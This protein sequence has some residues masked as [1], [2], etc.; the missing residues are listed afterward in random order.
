M[1]E[2]IKEC[3]AGL[4]TNYSLFNIMALYSFIQFTSSVLCEFYGAYPSDFGFLYWD[5]ACNFGFFMTFGYTKTVK[6]LSKDKPKTKLL[7][8]FNIVSLVFMYVVQLY[9][10]LLM[11]CGLH[12]F[13]D[14]DIGSDDEFDTDTP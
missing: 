11:L 3:R 12:W 14:V 6:K 1:V 5:L 10:Q 4:V 9:G 2:L 7:T 8:F 13:K